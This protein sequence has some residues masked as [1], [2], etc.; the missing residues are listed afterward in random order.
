[1]IEDSGPGVASALPQLFEF[2]RVPGRPRSRGG[3]GIGLAVVRGLIEA[4]GG[5]ALRR[6]KLG[7]L[8]GN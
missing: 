4:T 5:R 2:Y 3:L 1:V 8:A 6:V 7:G